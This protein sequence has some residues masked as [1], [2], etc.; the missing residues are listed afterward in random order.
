M[1]KRL[2]SVSILLLTAAALWSTEGKTAFEVTNKTGFVLSA[3]Y[4][5]E[6]NSEQWGDDLLGGNPLLDG[7][8]II[9]PIVSLKS[10]IVNIRARDEEGDTYTVY[11]VDAEKDDV[12]IVLTDIDPD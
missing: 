6:I 8:S 9:I 2:P 3:L 10:P 12:A 5:G 11:G 7:E 1:M 4:I